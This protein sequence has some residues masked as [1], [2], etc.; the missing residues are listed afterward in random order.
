MGE[1]GEEP[2]DLVEGWGIGGRALGAGSSF[3]LEVEECFP[4]LPPG[5]ASPFS[6]NGRVRAWCLRVG[7][8]DRSCISGVDMERERL[9]WRCKSDVLFFEFDPFVS[10]VEKSV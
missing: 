5:N 8:K 2:S 9:G 3:S 1:V 7:R 4:L 10:A 6:F